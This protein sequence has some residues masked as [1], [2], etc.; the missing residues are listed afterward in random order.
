MYVQIIDKSICKHSNN[1]KMQMKRKYF[2]YEIPK[3]EKYW[4]NAFWWSL[5]Q[6]HCRVFCGWEYK[7]VQCV[8]Y[9]F[10]IQIL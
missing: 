7:S 9:A 8:K 4:Q 10:K 2:V 3:D 5:G 1:L 6:W